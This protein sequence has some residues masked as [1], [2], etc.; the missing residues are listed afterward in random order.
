MLANFHDVQIAVDDGLPGKDGQVLRLGRKAHEQDITRLAI[1]EGDAVKACLIVERLLQ[2]AVRRAAAIARLVLIVGADG[3]GHGDNKPGAVKTYTGNPA[4]MAE[5]RIEA[6]ASGAEDLFSAH[7]VPISAYW[8][9][10]GMFE[11]P[12]KLSTLP[13]PVKSIGSHLSR[14]SS[15]RFRQPGISE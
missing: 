2:Q 12:P 3:L 15:S 7:R 10:V 5:W 1:S 9:L 4:L 14:Q 11:K 8:L 6:G 13:F